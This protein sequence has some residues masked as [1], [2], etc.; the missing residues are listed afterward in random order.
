VLN[1]R[2]QAALYES[3]LINIKLGR[4]DAAHVQLERLKNVCSGCTEVTSLARAI[5]QAAAAAQ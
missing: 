2:H 5:A 3:G 4:P 1:P